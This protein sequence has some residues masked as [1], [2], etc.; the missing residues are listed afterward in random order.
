L[1]CRDFGRPPLSTSVLFDV[2]VTDTN[3]NSPVFLSDAAIQTD[4]INVP[5]SS[6][7]VTYVAELFENNFIGAFV[8]QVKLYQ[9]PPCRTPATVGFRSSLRRVLWLY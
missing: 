4:A 9:F 3:D 5:V 1:V 6:G 7:L 8:A 2:I